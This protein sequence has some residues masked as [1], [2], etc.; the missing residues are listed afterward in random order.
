LKY[1]PGGEVVIRAMSAETKRGEYQGSVLT[2]AILEGLERRARELG[3]EFQI[4]SRSADKVR[5]RC[6]RPELHK[7]G[8]AHPS[9][10]YHLGKYVVCRVCEFKEGERKLAERLG[11]GAVE[12]GLTLSALAEAKKLPLEFLQAWGWRTQRGK[13]GKAKVLVPWYDQQGVKRTAPAYHIRNYLNKGDESGPR[14]TWDLPRG[15]R[16][17]PYGAWRV[18]EW[19]E[20]FETQGIES[21]AWLC[22]SEL[23]DLT[24]WHHG[25]PALGYGGASFWRREWAQYLARFHTVLLC[26]E[27]DPAGQRA[28]R[29][30]AMDL[31]EEFAALPQPP[32][33]L[34][35]PFS[36]GAKD[37]NALHQQVLGQRERFQE[38]LKQL[39]AQA[40]PASQLADEERNA[41]E[42]QGRREREEERAKLLDLA[43][44]LVEDPAVIHR[45]ILTAEELGVVGERRSVGL[46][47]LSVH[48]RALN[49]PVNVEVNSPSSSGKTHVVLGTLALEDP[50]AYYEMT[51]GSEKALIYLGEPLSHRILYIQEPEGL[52]EGVGAAV[53]KSLVW[54]GRLKYDTVVKE[55]GDL[56]G[57]HIEKDG[58]TGMIVTTTRPLDEQVSNRMLRLEVDTSHDQ[59]RRILQAIARSVNGDRLQIDLAPWHAMSRLLGEPAQVQ[60]LFSQWL[61]SKVSVTTLRIRRDFTHLLSLIQASAI[62]HRFQRPLAPDGSILANVADYAIVHS[63]AAD[64][65]RAVQGEGITQ[66]DRDTR[67]K[68]VELSQAGERPVSQAEL[69]QRL[70]VSKAVVSHRVNRLLKLDYLVNLET[71]RGRPAK[72]VP[73]APLPEEVPPLPS[74]CNLARHL[75]ATG[76]IDLVQPWVDP[77]TGQSHD[78]WAHLENYIAAQPVSGPDRYEHSPSSDTGSKLGDRSG[79]GANGPR[80]PPHDSPPEPA[81]RPPFG[82]GGER[83]SSFEVKA[84][85]GDRSGVHTVQGDKKG[86]RDNTG[87]QQPELPWDSFLEEMN[88]DEPDTG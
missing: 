5:V 9:A 72:L 11:I 83:S 50:E 82:E 44:P 34:V 57:R 49:R 53:L 10:V 47:R 45:A 29:V 58:P 14:F 27:P 85:E 36:E 51:A 4:N 54:E 87:V 66:A 16:L 31:V 3:D 46:L 17:V 33:V 13:D 78:C 61:A 12:G 75:L 77:L 19:L 86:G 73:G 65:F 38:S 6:F 79:V 84:E 35:C 23:D 70:V 15:V 8:D 28:A 41:Q 67:E 2:Q 60:V 42:A 39:L 18:D 24:F 40:I 48:S 7:N 76:R 59:T 69:R 56:V 26:Q 71:Q 64:L 32:E 21:Y 63:L 25:I 30:I 20:A 81:V 43:R 37:A 55:D 62:E 88:S 74:P 22:E 1:G 52:A 80:T 68:V